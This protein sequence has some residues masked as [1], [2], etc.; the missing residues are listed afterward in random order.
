MAEIR[1][2]T[3]ALNNVI[4]GYLELLKEATKIEVDAEGG[5]RMPLDDN[6]REAI[7]DTLDKASRA[8]VLGCQQGVYGLFLKQD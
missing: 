5:V 1:L 6:K 8:L 7:L 4:T 2:S 3:G